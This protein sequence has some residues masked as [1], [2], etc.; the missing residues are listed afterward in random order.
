MITINTLKRGEGIIPLELMPSMHSLIN[1]LPALNQAMQKVQGNGYRSSGELNHLYLDNLS[2][3]LPNIT[4]YKEF[5]NAM[6]ND[7]NL[8]NTI[9]SEI[10]SELGFGAKL[11]KNRYKF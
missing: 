4:N 2:V 3:T 11:N 1:G 9:K 6:L 7:S 10:G 8:M 5:R